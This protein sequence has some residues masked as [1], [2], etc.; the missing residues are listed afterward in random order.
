VVWDRTTLAGFDAVVISTA[1]AG[2]N[3]QE[4]AEWVGCIVDTR[5]VMAFVRVRSGQV[6]KA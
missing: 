4:L 5:N 6:W 3:Y 2:V 1:H